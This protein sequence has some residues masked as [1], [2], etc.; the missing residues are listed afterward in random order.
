MQYT[1]YKGRHH[2]KNV[3][4]KY[5]DWAAYTVVMGMLPL[6]IRLLLAS[7]FDIA[8]GFEDFRTELFFITIVLLVDALRNYKLKSGIWAISL[9]VLIASAAVYAVV[10]GFDLDLYKNG[11]EV[12]NENINRDVRRFLLAGAILDVP[13]VGMGGGSDV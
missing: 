6:V 12:S 4:S 11:I 3:G 1:S 13:S 7:S 8:I 2:T 9:F 10:L 5:R